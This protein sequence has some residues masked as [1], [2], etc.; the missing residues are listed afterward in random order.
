MIGEPRLRRDP[1]FDGDHRKVSTVAL[2]GFRVDR[3]RAGRSVAAAEIVHADDEELVGVKRLAGTDEIVPPADVAR[4]VGIDAGDVV[5]A[6]QGMAD[7]DGVR[8]RR[9]ERAVGFV[10]EV[11]TGQERAALERQRL[12]ETD[13]L[14]RN[15]SDGLF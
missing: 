6:G 1:V 10:H 2:A 8:A 9:V 12:I 7:E 14:R 4:I 11:E 3:D 5:T 13:P 15:D